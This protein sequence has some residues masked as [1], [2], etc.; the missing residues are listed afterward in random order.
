MHVAV[1]VTAHAHQDPARDCLVLETARFRI[2][3]AVSFWI[4]RRLD[5]E[6]VSCPGYR[7]VT[8]EQAI[9]DV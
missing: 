2:L 1:F 3:D 8:V 9:A 6:M 5:C 4:P 7:I